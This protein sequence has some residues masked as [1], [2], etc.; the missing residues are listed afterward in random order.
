[1]AITTVNPTGNDQ[2]P[3][4]IINYQQKITYQQ[5]VGK[6]GKI[7][8]M[9][10]VMKKHIEFPGPLDPEFGPPYH[11]YEQWSG[12]MPEIIHGSKSKVYFRY[13]LVI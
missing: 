5:K 11:G 12:D 9:G 6:R 10:S 7:I 13:P 1:L 3:I 8:T 2:D 4:I